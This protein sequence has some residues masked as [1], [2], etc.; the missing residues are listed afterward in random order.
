MDPLNIKLEVPDLPLPLGEDGLMMSTADFLPTGNDLFLGDDDDDVIVVHMDLRENLSTLRGLVERRIG[1]SLKHYEFWLQGSTMLESHKN[2]VDQCVQGEGLVQINVQVQPT[3]R[4]INIADVLK[5]T[6]EVLE[7][8]QREIEQ[9]AKEAEA[10]AAAK[11]AAEEEAAAAEAIA[12]AVAEAEAASAK[13]NAAEPASGTGE[14]DGSGAKAPAGLT[15]EAQETANAVAAIINSVSV[16]EREKERKKERQVQGDKGGLK[17]IP[18]IKEEVLGF[19]ENSLDECDESDGEM[20]DE[21][22][23]CLPWVYDSAFKR[24]QQRLNI[25]DDPNEWTVAQVKHW[26]Q[27]AVRTFNLN[28]I[29][30]Q[31]WS[32]SGKELCELDLDDFKLKAPNDPGGLFWMH[33]ELLRRHK[34]VATLQKPV[35]GEDLVEMTIRRKLPKPNIG[36]SKNDEFSYCGNRTG[37]NGQ[38]QLWQFLLEILTDREHRTIIQWIGTDGEFKLCNPEQVAQLWGE[39]KNKPTMNYEKLSRALRYY[40][41]GDMIS[42]VHGKRFVYKFVCDLRELLGYDA[43]ELASLVNE[44]NPD[45]QYG[46]KNY[47]VDFD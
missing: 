29:K 19:G 23:A 6:D 26:I 43:S 28:G 25:P 10:A 37:N 8:Y 15:K 7:S 35:D 17:L 32:I 33:L 42:K 31:D 22:A 12:A 44:G 2:L 39:R 34:I 41:D 24:D 40:Y 4:R 1:L 38:I 36:S 27:W 14:R 45:N 11:R 30:L 5:P 20:G 13:E 16:E 3:K 18:A 21:P 46:T 47:D 9:A